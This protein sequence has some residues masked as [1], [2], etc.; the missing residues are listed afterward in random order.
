[1]RS[2]A[3]AGVTMILAVGSASSDQTAN[4]SAPSPDKASPPGQHA[5][6]R[7]AAD[8]DASTA[9]AP[10]S[11]KYQ[12]E[13]DWLTWPKMTGDWGGLRT[14]L[15][16]HGIEIELRLSQ[17]YQGVA[18]GGANTK[19][20]YGGKLDYILNIDG[21]K[22][23][24][25]EGLFVTMHAETQFGESIN[26]DAG[27]FALPNTPMLYP[28]PNKHETAITG[29]LVQQALSKNFVL[30]GGKINAVDLWTMVYPHMGGGIDGFAN[31]NMIASAVPW[32]RWVNLSILGGG[33]LVLTDDGQIQGGVLA[34]DTNNSTTTTGID[35]LFDSGACVLGLWRFFFDVCDKPGSLLFAGGGSTRE[36]DSLAR[37]DWAFVPGLGLSGKKKDGAWTVGAYYDQVFWQ[38][39]DNDKKNLRLYTGWSLSDGNPSF[40]RWGGFAS[41]EG[42]G[43][44]PNREQDRMGVGGF[45]NQLSSD[46][47][48][49]ASA[50]GV[51]LRNTWGAELYYNAEITPWFHLTGVL[52]VVQNQNGSDD[53]AIILG[54]RAVID[55]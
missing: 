5:A 3:I 10:A 15:A 13:G 21:K 4:E 28:L 26:G 20:A 19:F 24:L 39:P 55:F 46:F 1:M 53:P 37:S 33:G 54:L 9:P 7:E 38:A 23:G 45:F 52:Q 14:D 51:N 34:F 44:L 43:L 2:L 12:S 32:L 49:L 40:G 31:T 30:A 47:K 35:E 25:W 16:E 41:V 18:S 6:A 50:I 11:N 36:Y 29:L 42:W 22:L 48:A 17:F 27:A 8:H